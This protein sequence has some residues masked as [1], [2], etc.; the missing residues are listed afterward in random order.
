MQEH[1]FSH[2]S[3]AGHDGFFNDVSITFIDK[4]DPSDPSRREDYWRQT[5][6]QWF[7]SGLILK[8]V[9]DGCFCVSFLYGNVSF[10]HSSVSIFQDFHLSIMEFVLSVYIVASVVVSILSLLPLILLSLSLSYFIVIVVVSI[11]PNLIIEVK[12]CPICTLNDLVPCS[13]G[14]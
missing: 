4:T 1:L 2:F 3:L 5:L 10:L 6:K 9:S 12:P 13:I 7:R 11:L 8:T 14:I